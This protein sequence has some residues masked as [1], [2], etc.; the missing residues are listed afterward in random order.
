MSDER[1]GRARPVRV[2]LA[3]IGAWGRNL[4]RNYAQMPG[5]D[6]AWICDPDPQRLAEASQNYPHAVCTPDY[7]RVLA[8]PQLDAVVIAASATAHFTLGRQALM[9]GKDVY[10]EKPLVLEVA[11]GE[12][13]I[14]LAAERGRVLM[15]GHLLEYHPVVL[16]L[17]EMIRAGDLGRV[18][19]VYSQRLN[20]GTVRQDENALWSLAP[21]DISSILFML[22][23]VPTD[24]SA[25]GQC[26]VQRGIE[27]VV[28]MNMN[29][30]D[31]AMAHVHVSWLDPHKIRRITVVG[32]RR[33]AVFDDA[34]GS[35]KLRIYD[36]GAT[37]GDHYNT[38]AE[39][40]GLRFG[41]I[42]IPYFKAVEPLR[43][44]CQHFLDC[45][46]DRS[47]PVSDGHDGLRVVQVL[48]AAQRSLKS[49]GEPQP[50]SLSA[51][52]RVAA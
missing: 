17:R 3:G 43:L 7:A 4:A 23:Q 44:E 40:V 32:S 30:A 41:D 9:A 28:F 51:P 34:D 36:K 39:S 11:D 26:Y 45:V 27:D 14:R 21:H 18:L 22:D 38:F 19:Y 20:L 48:E 10:I 8:D 31:Q 25:R 46:R 33:M 5:A 6:L 12:E 42:Q 29:F 1:D 16:K 49:N 13:L 35:E 47:R 50:L 24:V 52:P 2:G 37:V 15:V